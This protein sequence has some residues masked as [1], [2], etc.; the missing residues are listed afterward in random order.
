MTDERL[1]NVGHYLV[2]FCLHTFERR[3]APFGQPV[4]VCQNGTDRIFLPVLFVNVSTG[5]SLWCGTDFFPPRG[6]R[7]AGP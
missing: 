1:S 6:I 2:F 5:Q 3:G 4:S 7:L